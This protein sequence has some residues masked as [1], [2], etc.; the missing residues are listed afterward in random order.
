VRTNNPIAPVQP[1]GCFKCGE[2][3]HYANNCPKHNMQTPQNQKNSR[4]RP[5]Q[6]SSQAHNGTPNS[7]GNKGQQNYMRGRVNDVTAETAQEASNVVLSM[8]L[9][10][11]E[12]ASVLFDSR[13][14]NSFIKEQFVAKHNLPMHPMKQS[15][16]ISSLGKEFKAS[17]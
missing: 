3:G 10:N 5:G 12:F 4:Q 9:V 6:Q 7:Q 8:F 16:V 2:V 1:N 15:L 13:V 11:S 17:H 14:S